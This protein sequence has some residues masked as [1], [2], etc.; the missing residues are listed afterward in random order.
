MFSAEK[1]AMRRSIKPCGLTLLPIVLLIAGNAAAVQS[2]GVYVVTDA[3]FGAKADGVTDDTAAFTGAMAV[4]SGVGGGVVEVPAG[5]YR[6]SGSLEVPSNVTLEGVSPR[7]V[8]GADPIAPGGSVLLATAGAADADGTPFIRLNTV[9]VLKGLSIYYPD[10][11][12]SA[13]PT[14]YP[15]TVR[16]NANADNCTLI[17]V[18]IVNAYQA[19]DFGTYNVGRHWIDGLATQALSIGLYVHQCYD[20]G[21]LRDVY[22]GPIWTT[23]PAAQYMRQN[24]VAF[25]FGRTDGEQA[26]TCRAEGYH[27]GFHFIR[28]PIGAGTSPGSGVMKDASTTACTTS[29][30]VEDAGDNAGWS[31]V[32]GTFEGVVTNGGNQKGEFKFYESTFQQPPGASRHA[33]LVL[34]S[35]LQKPFF[36]ERCTFGPLTGPDPVAM[37]C[38]DYAVIVMNCTF[39]GLPGDVKVRLSAGVREAVVVRN[40]MHG[41]VTVQNNTTSGADVQ[42]GLNVTGDVG[43]VAGFT[44]DP[45]SGFAPLTVQ[46]TDAST[47]GTFPISSWNWDFGDGEGSTAQNPSHN[48]LASGVYTVSLTVRSGSDTPVTFTREAYIT[49]W[50][51][52]MDSDNDGIADM[53]EG[54]GDVD[55]DGIPNLLD[56]DSDNDGILDAVEGAGDADGDDIPNF[57]DLD[58]DDDGIPDSL[59]A[60]L[61]TNPLD[62]NSPVGGVAGLPLATRKGT[63]A[64][65][66]LM[67]VAGVFCL[68][69]KG[70]ILA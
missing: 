6:I 51:P 43:P 68:R 10:Q 28:G 36:F 66:L 30:Y 21:R 25:R 45:T 61:G 34:R 13:S 12:D 5:T 32:G 65:A 39:N 27:T 42:V 35:G 58:S 22:F 17:D 56:S 52:T 55:N 26:S 64:M 29:F 8:A 33:Q 48:Y 53:V 4:A 2:A 44:A 49:V 3:P 62:P 40:T 24:G 41:G 31:F 46:F 23:G 69:Q 57:L 60:A 16:G 19:V 47:A 18:T 70:V 7:F 9:S 14:A 67:V 1:T 11:T 15:W 63:A 50:S 38:N 20:V 37:D 59:E 54:A